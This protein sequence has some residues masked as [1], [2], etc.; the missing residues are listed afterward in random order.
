MLLYILY[1]FVL[2]HLKNYAF[3]AYC[4]YVVISCVCALCV[5]A[6]V[7]VHAVHILC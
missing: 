3:N 2:S 1:Y 5:R 7:C 6:C 4:W